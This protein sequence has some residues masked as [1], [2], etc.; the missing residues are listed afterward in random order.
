MAKSNLKTSLREVKPK[1]SD[2][3][4]I[5]LPLNS[6]SGE[7]AGILKE[8]AFHA[9]LTLEVRR[10]ERSRKRF[11]LLLLE[12]RDVPSNGN[13]ASGVER[14]AATVHGA[15]RETDVFGWYQERTTLGVIFTEIN[16]EGD[17]PITEVLQSKI[18]QAIKSD[19]KLQ[20]RV[21][22]TVRLLPDSSH[23]V[24]PDETTDIRMYRNSVGK[25][26]RKRFSALAKR[27]VDVVGSL[28]LLLISSPI[29]AIV[30]LAIKLNSEGPVIFAQERIGQS[31]KAFRF[32]KFRTMYTNNDPKIHR[33][34]VKRFISG[35]Q[36]NPDGG[37]SAVYKITSD[38]R[39]TAVGKFLRRAS[40]D[41][42]PQFWNV[43][44]GEMS[45][46]GP[47]PPLPYEF[48]LYDFWHRRRVLEIKPGVTGL[49]Q[50]S[51]R[52]RLCFD[53]MVRLDL[54]YFREWSLWLDLKILLATPFAVLKGD[55]AF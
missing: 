51:G 46:V 15:I 25:N 38:P 12:L 29:L 48:E 6:L 55:G 32:L 3:R 13:G 23:S 45:L 53:E 35:E 7:Q 49:W 33:E 52:S 31:G 44:R 39:I 9:M 34:Y 18:T 37:G 16:V 50:V 36:Q 26:S 17:I 28:L 14:L 47:R 4:K 40:L 27:T 8:E 1:S 30:A 5:V 41:E 42:F 21:A 24:S 2:D 19:C 10:A 20:G 11:A 22:I 54:R 43:L